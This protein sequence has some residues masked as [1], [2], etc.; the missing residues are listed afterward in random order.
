MKMKTYE[1]SCGDSVSTAYSGLNDSVSD[2]VSTAYSGLN[3]RFSTAYSGLNVF[4]WR[5]E[6][7]CVLF[8]AFRHTCLRL[9]PVAMCAVT[10]PVCCHDCEV[11]MAAAFQIGYCT[12]IKG[13]VTREALP[14]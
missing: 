1:F 2:S 10:L 14:L 12:L 3:D 13:G 11:V 4:V 6:V 8:H 7:W 5:V 9:R